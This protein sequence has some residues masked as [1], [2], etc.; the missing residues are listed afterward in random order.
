M[1]RLTKIARRRFGQVSSAIAN[2]SRQFVPQ[3][4]NAWKLALN[5]IVFLLL[6]GSFV[7]LAMGWFDNRHRRRASAK[8]KSSQSASSHPL[9]AAPCSGGASGA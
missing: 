5:L 4:M 8:A 1:T 3:K 7:V 9:L 6:G 2:A